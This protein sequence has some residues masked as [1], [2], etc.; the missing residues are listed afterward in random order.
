MTESIDMES[1]HTIYSHIHVHT[2]Y[3]HTCKHVCHGD[4]HAKLTR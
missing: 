2:L 4:G 3:F 1:D